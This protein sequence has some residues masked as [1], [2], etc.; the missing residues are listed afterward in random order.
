MIGGALPLIRLDI[1]MS[2]AQA[3]WV[4]GTAFA[5]PYGVT[6]LTLAAVLRGRRPSIAW[7]I[8]GV[9][10][11]TGASLAT[12]VAHSI[13]ALTIAR[14]AL[15]IGQAMFVPVAIAW[16]VDGA[17]QDAGPGKTSIGRARALAIFTSGS[18]IGRSAA[19]LAVG[20]LLSVLALVARDGG[21]IAHW[22]WLYMLTALPNVLMLPWLARIGMRR[23]QP[24]R[25]DG[26][27]AEPISSPPPARLDWT[28]LA[29]FFV[30]A[31]MPIV[32]IQAIGGWLPSLFVRARGLAPAQAAMLIGAVTLFAA[33]AGQILGGWL[34]TRYAAWHGRI[35]V[36]V[37][38]GLTATLLPLAG[39]IWAPGL[40]GAIIATAI[41]NLTLGIASFCGLFGVQM[42]SPRTHRVTVNGVFLALVTLVGVGAGPLLTGV[43]ATIDAHGTD[44]SGSLGIALLKTGVAAC[45]VCAVAVGAVRQRYR[46]YQP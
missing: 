20:A 32:V 42:L 27:S 38:A 29:L 19:L 17:D 37:L 24:V 45:A 18:T 10:L 21:S 34:M 1:A 14:A 15:G 41:L 25:V 39:V 11:W 5:V 16:L 13:G 40:S 43:I 22:R 35:P 33:P 36:I 31:V 7:L 8:G 4:I 46:R 26:A 3:G 12:G 2:D 44:A 23:P 9:V 30:V 6:A 28:T